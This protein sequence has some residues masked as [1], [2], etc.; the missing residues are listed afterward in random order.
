MADGRRVP[1]EQ[2]VPGDMVRSLVVP[3]LKTD[4]P[5]QAQYQWL[6]TWGLE[7]AGERPGRVAEVQLGEHNGFFLINRRIKVTFEHP[8]LVR[9]GDEWGFCST[10]QLQIGDSLIQAVGEGSL[11]EERIDMIERVAGR[12]RT[13]ALHVPGTNTYLV[14]GVWT[15]NDAKSSSTAFDT[16]AQSSGHTGFSNSAASRIGG[17]AISA[18]S[19]SSASSSSS[20][21]KSSGS[22]FSS[23]GSL[24]LTAASSATGSATNSAVQ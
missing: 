23:S 20:G 14:D 24:T 17:F 18:H 21:S 13:V 2:I 1:I 11:A 4:V 22:S 6:S 19:S 15:H 10:D 12:V 7:G 16:F 9:R 3:G 8:F 5:F